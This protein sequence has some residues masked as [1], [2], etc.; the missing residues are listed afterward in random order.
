M[1]KTLTIILLPFIK[2]ATVWT[3][4]PVVPETLTAKSVIFHAREGGGYE[5]D[6]VPP[7]AVGGGLGAFHKKKNEILS[8]SM[9]FNAFSCV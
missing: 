6:N 7:L 1:L 3:L 4:S 9:C 5:R 2:M 8:S